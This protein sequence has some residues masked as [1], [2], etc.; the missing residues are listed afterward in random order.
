MKVNRSD[1][2]KIDLVGSVI[3]EL[4]SQLSCDRMHFWRADSAIL[5]ASNPGTSWNVVYCILRESS[6]LSRYKTTLPARRSTRESLTIRLAE[7]DKLKHLGWRREQILFEVPGRS[8]SDEQQLTTH[9][10]R[11]KDIEFTKDVT[12]AETDQIWTWRPLLENGQGPW[13]LFL[14]TGAFGTERQKNWINM[15]MYECAADCTGV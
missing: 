4:Y 15:E 2:Y 10:W 6:P 8:R 1:G 13:L 14:Y 12:Q 7:I 3:D 5:A 9:Y 11:L